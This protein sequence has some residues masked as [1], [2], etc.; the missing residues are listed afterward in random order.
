MKRNVSLIFKD[1]SRD[2]LSSILNPF[3]SFNSPV[4]ILEVVF[5]DQCKCMEAFVQVIRFTVCMESIFV[6]EWDLVCLSMH[7][8]VVADTLRAIK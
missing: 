2:F 8:K 7:S 1:I 3:W 5:A 4:E 6:L